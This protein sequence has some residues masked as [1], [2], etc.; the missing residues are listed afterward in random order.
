MPDKDQRNIHEE[1][2][3]LPEEEYIAPEVGEHHLDDSLENEAPEPEKSSVS[4]FSRAFS[5]LPQTRNMR[6][7]LVVGVVVVLFVIFHFLHT[8]RVKGLPTPAPQI[9]QVTTTEPPPPVA[10]TQT[11]PQPIPQQSDNALSSLGALQASTSENTEKL[12]NMQSQISDMQTALAQSQ[13]SNQQLQQ[14]LTTLTDQVN[15]VT[16][17][18]NNLLAALDS[19][20]GSL[21]SRIVYH[22]RA[23]LPDRAWIM[24]NT[25]ETLTVTIGD[26][27][28]QYG[29]VQSID[30]QQ[31]IIG[32][33]SG[34]K[35][36]YGRNDF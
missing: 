13:A 6:I 28:Q 12:N 19:G 3:Q 32:T 27:I 11:Q 23:I 36:Y 17:R 4:A 2:Y 29:I 21:S 33:S 24:S 1:E 14:A 30:P 8:G 10:Q 16:S 26:R 7:L 35:I 5:H 20:K 15:T 34:R 9:A 25:G 18:L 22:I 31:G